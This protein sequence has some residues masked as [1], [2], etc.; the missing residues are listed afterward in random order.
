[1]DLPIFA[2]CLD[3]LKCIEDKPFVRSTRNKFQS[4]VKLSTKYIALYNNWM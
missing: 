4:H 1:M 3:H 2:S